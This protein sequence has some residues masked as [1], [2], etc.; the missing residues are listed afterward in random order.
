MGLN[1]A[2]EMLDVAKA[3]NLQ[4]ERE[5][6]RLAHE[7]EAAVAALDVTAARV[8]TLERENAALRFPE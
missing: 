5:N 7:L 2:Q 8:R 1:D 3:D 4:L 6:A